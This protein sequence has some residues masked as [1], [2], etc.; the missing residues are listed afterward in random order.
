MAQCEQN[1]KKSKM[2][3]KQKPCDPERV[4][5]NETELQLENPTHSFRETNI[6]LQ[7]I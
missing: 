4:N 6:V 5:K 3:D 2:F 1:I 7:L